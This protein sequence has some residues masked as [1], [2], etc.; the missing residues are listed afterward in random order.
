MRLWKVNPF[1]LQL[2]P[3]DDPTGTRPREAWSEMFSRPIFDT[4]LLGKSLTLKRQ[5]PNGRRLRLVRYGGQRTVILQIPHPPLYEAGWQRKKCTIKLLSLLLRT[6]V[7]SCSSGTLR[8]G[9]AQFIFWRLF[10]T[11]NRHYPIKILFRALL[12]NACRN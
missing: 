5:L 11:H 2:F 8:R 3:A 9:K 10:P 1:W 7:F 4:L 12:G 6:R